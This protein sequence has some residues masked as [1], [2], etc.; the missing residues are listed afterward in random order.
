MKDL[1][2]FRKIKSFLLLFFFKKKNLIFLLGNLKISNSNSFIY[3][4][5]WKSQFHNYNWTLLRHLQ[6]LIGVQNMDGNAFLCS[7][8]SQCLVDHSCLLM[9]DKK[10]LRG[11]CKGEGT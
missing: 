3:I 10:Y 6:L 1:Y 2:Y 9:A 11:N 4:N 5:R 8:Y 7:L